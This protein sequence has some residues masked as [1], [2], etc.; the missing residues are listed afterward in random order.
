MYYL[1]IVL[2]VIVGVACGYFLT[3]WILGAFTSLAAYTIYATRKGGGG[4]ASGMRL[5][6]HALILIAV[7]CMWL[8]FL[9]SRFHDPQLFNFNNYILR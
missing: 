7:V 6:M 5:A 9:I 2:V 4:E 1:A 3:I 8:S